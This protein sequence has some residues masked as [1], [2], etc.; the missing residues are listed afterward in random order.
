M[1][2]IKFSFVFLMVSSCSTIDIEPYKNIYNSLK[3]DDFDYVSKINSR[4]SI[5]RDSHGKS[6]IAKYESTSEDN[7]IWSLEDRFFISSNGRVIQTSGFKND[8][9]LIKYEGIVD[10]GKTSAYIKFSNPETSLLAINFT[11]TTIKQ[12]DSQNKF[13][14]IKENMQI[15]VIRYSKDNYY[16][17]DRD[18]NIAKSKQFL[19]PFEGKTRITYM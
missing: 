9:K 14:I 7:I 11:Y 3:K 16:W 12:I 17:Y 5:Y 10:D 2:L 1:K 18:G 15:P 8:F 19:I 6:H 4:T 13:K